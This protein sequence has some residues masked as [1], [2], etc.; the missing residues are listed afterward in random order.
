MCHADARSRGRSVRRACPRRGRLRKRSAIAKSE[1]RGERIAPRSNAGGSLKRYPLPGATSGASVQVG[2][3]GRARIAY[4]TSG[5][6]RY[7]VFNGSGFDWSAIP[8][9]TK[10]D[11]APGLVLD[12]PDNAHLT[13]L[14][15][16]LPHG[17]GER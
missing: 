1:R 11:T 16:D 13:Y 17:C 6:L 2:Y 12:A 10:L 8:G 3:D 15:N 14:H 9:T 5:A 4:E 7:A